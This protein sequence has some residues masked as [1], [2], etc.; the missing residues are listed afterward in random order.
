ML[1][2]VLDN[3]MRKQAQRTFIKNKHFCKQLRVK[4]KQ[5]IV[6]MQ[7][8]QWGSPHG[9]KNDV[10]VNEGFVFLLMTVN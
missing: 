6:F 5:N 10:T 7:K 2:D 3:D 4:T 8:W 9:T 1:Q